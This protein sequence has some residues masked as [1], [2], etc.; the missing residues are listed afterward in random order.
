[1]REH[2]SKL[3]EYR[4]IH[5]GETIVVCGCGVSLNEFPLPSIYTTIGVNDVGRKFTPDYL[6]VLNGKSQF[7][8]DRYQFVEKSQAKAIFS[9]L[10]LPFEHRQ[11]VQ[12]NLGKRGGVYID[13][14]N[15]LPYTRNSPY[16][17]VCLAAYMG[18]K[19]IGIIGLD[20]TS[21]HFYSNTG[22]HS[23]ERHIEKINVEY[24]R[25]A[26]SLRLQGIEFLN[27]SQSSRISSIKKE[28]ITSFFSTSKNIPG[29]QLMT[30]P[31]RDSRDIS[32]MKSKIVIERHKPGIVGDFLDAL[33]DTARALH[34][35]VSRDVRS[36]AI[37]KGILSVVWNGRQFNGHGPVLYC[38][39]GW[40][41]R[42]SYQISANGINAD[43]HIAPF[44]W[45]GKDLDGKQKE[46]LDSHLHDIRNGCPVDY[47]YMQTSASTVTEL[48]EAFILVPLQMEWDTNI[49]RHVPR[50][51]QKMKNLIVDIAKANP[52]L[53]IIYKQH[54]ADV[55][56][57]NRQMRLKLHRQQDKIWPHDNGNIHQ[58]LKSGRCRG[59][60]SLNSNVVHD[61]LIWDVP[62]IVLGRNI[63]P[64]Q[65]MGPFL[66]HL[67]KDWSD[68]FELWSDP[69]RRASRD[70]YAYYLMKNQWSLDDARDEQKFAQL[71][72]AYQKKNSSPAE[73][74]VIH[75]KRDYLPVINVAAMDRGW[76][77]EDLKK[78]FLG[79]N[80]KR[81]IIKL[82]ERPIRNADGWIFIRTK[83]ASSS[84]D[85]VRTVVHVHD[86]FDENLYQDN[87][88][89]HCI[90]FC[91]GIVL[92]HPLQRD[93]LQAAGIDLEQKLVL[94]KPIGALQAFTLRTKHS[95][96]FT[97]AWVGRPVI[98]FNQDLKR[99]DWFVNVAKALKGPIRAVLLG[100][101][102]EKEFSDLQKANIDC[103]YLTK[104]RYPIERYPEIYQDFDCLLI[105]SMSEAGPLSLFEALATG[106]PVVSTS[107]GWA[108][109][110]IKPG[111]NGYLADSIEE[112]IAAVESIQRDSAK[113]FARRESIQQS[114]A[115]FTLE[116]WVEDNISL[117]LRL[118]ESS[119]IAQSGHVILSKTKNS[120][121]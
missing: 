112:Q 13:S 89:R 37:D 100:E 34:Y 1:M 4:D 81:A 38:E 79:F 54:P 60:I 3:N 88:D 26:E 120:K 95:Q 59:I 113:W 121:V 40:L 19:R 99:T 110:L 11:K 53:P 42:W 94:E 73:K 43:S 49:Q 32:A 67:P 29:E 22:K 103:R 58:L 41:P 104:S 111:V 61:G 106:I 44:C 15:T 76:F 7:K 65:G 30:I 24:S 48:P 27:L 75:L 28:K 69:G 12:F 72:S 86:M 56:R 50:R 47:K 118:L 64:R 8:G 82:S 5:A 77:F 93:I 57:G 9:H 108:P 2:I 117:T 101:R 51:Y 10:S 109:Y 78:H 33:A 97:L 62:S 21:H 98:H 23:L 18:A 80:G 116:S 52:P 14:D 102:L 20:F 83:E 105:S 91:G 46:E 31:K 74:K 115:G 114:V 107:V 66:N 63:W 92:T 25:L 16:V 84:P 96:P 119:S 36:S 55:R 90:K 45:D 87:G 6:V 35:Q 68:L 70:A 71:L 17:A 85:P 39:H